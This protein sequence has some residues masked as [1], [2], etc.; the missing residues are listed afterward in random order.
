MHFYEDG[1]AL[2]RRA[3]PAQLCRD[4]MFCVAP[5]SRCFLHAFGANNNSALGHPARDRGLP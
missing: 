5:G 2:P 3:T 4:L 1:H